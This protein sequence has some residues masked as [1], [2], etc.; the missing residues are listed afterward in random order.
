MPPLLVAEEQLG[1][2]DH[3]RPLCRPE[4]Q[5][6]REQLADQRIHAST[7]VAKASSQ[8][9]RPSRSRTSVSAPAL[10]C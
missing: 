6:G 2:P 8:L 5:L 3:H 4:E 1:E 9:P 7:V 10:T